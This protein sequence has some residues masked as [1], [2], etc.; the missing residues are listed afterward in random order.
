MSQN[1]SSGGTTDIRGYL[2]RALTAER[3]IRIRGQASL[4]EAIK[5]R[6]RMYSYR[7][8]DRQESRRIYEPDMPQFGT[9]VYDQLTI[10]I[11]RETFDLTITKVVMNREVEEL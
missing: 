10:D 3:G 1:N 11:D 4:P 6:Q 5:L 7:H 2:D 8:W 9:S